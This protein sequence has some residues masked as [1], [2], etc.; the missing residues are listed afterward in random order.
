M[1]KVKFILAIIVG[2]SLMG[3]SV[4]CVFASEEDKSIVYKFWKKILPFDDRLE[5]QNALTG[6]HRH[7]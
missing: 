1:K 3:A 7:T 5:A 6:V 2:L 4:T